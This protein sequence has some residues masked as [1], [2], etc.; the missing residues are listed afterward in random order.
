MKVTEVRVFKNE[1]SSARVGSATITFDNIFVVSGLGIVNGQNGL[2]ISMPSKKGKDE[3]WKDICFPLNKEFRQEIQDA[4]LLEYNKKPNT[5][6][7]KKQKSTD[8]EY[9]F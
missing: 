8:E 5:N 7:S 4:V 3:E 1:G 6:I 9:P 2:F